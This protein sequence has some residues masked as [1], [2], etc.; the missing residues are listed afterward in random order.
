MHKAFKVGSCA[1]RNERN[2]LGERKDADHDFF[3]KVS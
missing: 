1:T 2:G 3:A